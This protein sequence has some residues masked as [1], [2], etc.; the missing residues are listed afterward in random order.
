MLYG[1]LIWCSVNK[2]KLNNK[3]LELALQNIVQ[4]L[5]KYWFTFYQGL[6]QVTSFHIG[7]LVSR[8]LWSEA[9]EALSDT[10]T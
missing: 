1:E 4:N 2:L 10:V 9:C 7:S 8:P 5:M 3:Q 6:W